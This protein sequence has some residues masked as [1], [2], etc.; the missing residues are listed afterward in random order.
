[1]Y[2]EYPVFIF[3]AVGRITAPIFFYLLAMGYRRTRDANRYTLRLLVFACISYVPYI[4]YFENALPNKQNFFELNVIFT[5]LIGL[6]LLRSVYEVKYTAVKIICIVL[7]VLVGYWCD[8]GLYGI[9]MILICDVC[10]DSRLRTILGLASVM[11]AYI[12]LNLGRVFSASTG[13]FEYMAQIDANTR[14]M[15]YLIVLLCQF[16]PLIFI[17]RH[18]KWYSGA[19]PEKRPSFPA[20][21]GF[22]IFY[23]AHITLFLL[24]RL[25]FI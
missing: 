24:I 7:C 25:Y 11:M 23:P 19:A 20:K 3:H 9:A 8:Y 1:M 12:Y 2:Y 21:W 22:Y 17:A 16:L 13:P 10:R 4:W 6:L 15:F 14:I 5:M 18:R